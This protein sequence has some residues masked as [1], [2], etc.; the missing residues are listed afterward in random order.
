MKFSLRLIALIFVFLIGFSNVVIGQSIPSADRLLAD[1]Q[2]ASNPYVA[3]EIFQEGLLLYP[4]D[5]RFRQG[6]ETS[7]NTIMRW[8]RNSHTR[9]SFPAAINGYTFIIETPNIHSRIK[10]QAR[11]LRDFAMANRQIYTVLTS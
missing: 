8:S 4:N 3:M 6:I 1:G 2:A 7:A 11:I 10:D 9:G 5:N